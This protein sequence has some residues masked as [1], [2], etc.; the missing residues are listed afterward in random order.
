[1]NLFLQ[2]PVQIG[3]STILREALLPYQKLVGGFM[4]QRLFED[5]AMC[6]FR[7]CVVDG[8]LPA[9]DG[10]Y[11]DGLDGVFLYRGQATP[12]VL[13]KAVAGALEVC[14]EVRCKIIILDEIGGM[15]LLS[16]TFMASLNKIL[17]LGK[18]CLGVI[19]SRENLSRT[20]RG[21]ELPQHIL[22]LRDALQ[23]TIGENG[24][25]LTVAETGCP[26]TAKAVNCFVEEALRP[27]GGERVF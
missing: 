14:A 21:L 9:V 6:G 16:Q 22:S 1:M 26:K 13:E 23:Q 25:V 20:A 18:P 27:P 24:N 3:K 15:E 19:K 17:A 11:T 12:G 8:A 10:V 2:G 5:G 4:V 7:A